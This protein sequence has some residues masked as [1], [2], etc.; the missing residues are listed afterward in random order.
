[1][2]SR[3]VRAE[4][5]ASQADANDAAS[6]IPDLPASGMMRR[7]IR[8]FTDGAV[9][10]SRGF[11]EDLFGQERWRFGA[12]RQS[13]ARRMRGSASPAHPVLWSLRDLRH[14]VT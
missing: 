8:Y 14:H 4:L 6:P 11:V 13:G 10:G 1:M 3:R 5:D 7:R 9:I 12:R 2:D